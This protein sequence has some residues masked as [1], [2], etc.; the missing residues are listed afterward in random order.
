MALL[1]LRLF[2]TR[3]PAKKAKLR[4]LIGA[5][6]IKLGTGFQVGQPFK[7]PAN[8]KQPAI[9]GFI[10]NLYYNFKT[11]S[12]THTMAK[13]PVKGFSEKFLVNEERR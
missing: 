3:N 6:L 10:S 8:G 2:L 1:F 5:N 11:N 12:I 7:I 13:K 9:N 4:L